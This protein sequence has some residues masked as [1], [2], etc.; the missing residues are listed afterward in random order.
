MWLEVIFQYKSIG[1]KI[2]N[3][4]PDFPGQKPGFSQENIGWMDF[5]FKRT[6]LLTR[7]ENLRLEVNFHYKS[8][9]AIIRNQK[10]VFPDQKDLKNQVSDNRLDTS[11]L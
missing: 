10:Y 9:G 8:I 3:Q 4:K 1:G 5:L 2:R 7:S 6:E 11:T